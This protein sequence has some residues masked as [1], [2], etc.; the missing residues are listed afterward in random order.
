MKTKLIA[1]DER[2]YIHH[3]TK[4]NHSICSRKKVPYVSGNKSI[5]AVSIIA[6]HPDEGKYAIVRQFRPT[7]GEWVYE[8]PAGK[9][10]PQEEV[11]VAARRELYEETGL[12]INTDKD[13]QLV[14]SFPSVGLTDE[15]RSVLYCHCYGQLTDKNLDKGE[16]IEP[17]LLSVCDLEDLIEEPGNLFDSLIIGFVQGSKYGCFL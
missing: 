2:Y 9:I 17:M 7:I 5:D 11:I 15:Q 13:F 12:R 6:F 14:N 8:F 3:E 16:M 10:E 1:S 4:H